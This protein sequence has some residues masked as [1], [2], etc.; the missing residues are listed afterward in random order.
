MLA[1]PTFHED[2]VG[3]RRVDFDRLPCVAGNDTTANSGLFDANALYGMTRGDV[4]HF[5]LGATGVAAAGSPASASGDDARLDA[6]CA[7]GMRRVYSSDPFGSELRET[8]PGAN[9]AGGVGFTGVFCDVPCAACNYNTG[10]C[11]WDGVDDVARCKCDETTQNV[12]RSLSPLVPADEFGVGYAGED[13][14]IPCVPCKHGS[15]GREAHTHGLCVCDPGFSDPACAVECGAPGETIAWSAV[16]FQNFET[17]MVARRAEEARLRALE[18]TSGDSGDADG[19]GTA[20][21]GDGAS[22]DGATPA[23][24]ATEEDD[25]EFSTLPDE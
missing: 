9:D 10:A 4:D 3:H 19:A 12:A 22:G 20:G 16:V 24:P 17:K 5:N 14:S 6:Y 13:C 15:C 21:D 7:C 23:T 8:V 2:A 25:Y 18:G 11:V 1:F